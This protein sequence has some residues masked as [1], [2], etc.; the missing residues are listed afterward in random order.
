MMSEYEINMSSKRVNIAA[1]IL[2]LRNKN[3][4]QIL[5]DGN[6]GV[7][8]NVV[9]GGGLHVE[10]ELSVHHITAPVEIQ[11][12]EPVVGYAK[13]LSTKIIGYVGGGGDHHG[14]GAKV[15]GSDTVDT[16][17]LHPH[18]HPFKNV[19][20]K[21]M[22]SKDDVRKVGAKTTDNQGATAAIPVVH[23]KKTGEP[24]PTS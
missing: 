21:L 7:K 16:I 19:P 13:T 1:E 14:N 22:A 5:V 10:G 15:Y 2:T 18:T 8:Q 12:T 9:I 11:E 17:E 6:L 4:R 3:N 20:L 23:E 24:G